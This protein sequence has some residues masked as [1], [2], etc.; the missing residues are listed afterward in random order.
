MLTNSKFWILLIA[1]AAGLG[2]GAYHINASEN[3]ARATLQENTARLAELDAA[4]AHKRQALEDMEKIGREIQDATSKS[5]ELLKAKAELL[6]KQ[7]QI[8]NEF[9]KVLDSMTAAVEKLRSNAPGSE[10]GDLALTNG[11]SLR[12]VKIR[13]VSEDG[14]ALIH[15]DG[16]GTIAVDLLPE[17]LKEKYDIGPN[18]SVPKLA[19]VKAALLAKLQGDDVGMQPKP[20]VSNGTGGASA[21]MA[22]QNSGSPPVIIP[23]LEVAEAGGTKTYANVQVIGVSDQGVKVSHDAGI[24]V[25]PMASLPEAWRAKYVPSPSTT[26]AP[27]P[28]PSSATAASTSS[29]SAPSTSS[30]DPNC[31][32]F[33]KTDSGAG[34][35]FIA[36]ANDKTYVYTN[37]HVICGSPGGFTKKI[38]SI[39]TAAGRTIPTPY[40]LE[41]SSMYDASSSNGLEDM[42]R[43]PI[44]L[45]EG[46]V[47]YDLGGLDANTSM[48]QKVVAYGNSLGGDVITSL[49]G[50]IMGLGT[51]R[52]EIN[53]E[54]VPGNSGGPVVMADTKKVIGIS[55][56]LTTGKRDIW[57]S[58]TTFNQVRR[59]ALRPEKVTKW[60]KMLYT[61]LM[62][63][64]EEL[65]AFDRDTLSLAAAC[66][67]NPKPNRGGFDVPS[68]RNG[69]YIVR[70]V[71]VD[72]GS[73][74]LG[75]TINT[76]I[77]KVNQRLG[78][79]TATMSV[80]SVVPVFAEFFRSVADA[81]ASQM[82]SLQVAD[83]APYLKQFIPELIGI[84]KEIHERFIQ[85]G[86]TR[87][88]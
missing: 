37:A 26:P 15:S 54:I 28:S 5:Q 69:D 7:T 85:E 31:L 17:N 40:D 70:Q 11:K 83:R 73:H 33:I 84:R 67:L 57:A 22:N 12:G 14:I 62:S 6:E 44:S 43:F 51:D 38:V 34:S 80:T 18:A 10:L 61:S 25:F 68:Q 48:S 21:A 82:S 2:Y 32:V 29:R 35:G 60:R 47:A 8:G 49:E 36:R 46:E 56:Y 87:Y 71:L 42:A 64:L 78:G 65:R 1:A 24:S 3:A 86:V 39:K 59:F 41:L 75:G 63:S 76:G 13:K 72:G 66:F 4:L 50:S 52:I 20:L 16:I 55:T 19:A 74:S 23:K 58:G 88:R 27:M 77:A 81:S 53:C 79:A 30:F 45:K 9:Q